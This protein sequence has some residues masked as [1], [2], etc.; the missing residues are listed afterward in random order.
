MNIEQIKAVVADTPYDFLRKDPRLGKNIILLTLG[1]AMHTVW[2]KKTV[3][4][5]FEGLRCT[6]SRRSFSEKIFRRLRIFLPIQRFILLTKS[7]NC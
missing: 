4:W 6:A 2:K 5:I 7:S 1:E 3:T